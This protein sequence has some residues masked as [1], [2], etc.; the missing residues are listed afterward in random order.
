MQKI[1]EK[2][3]IPHALLFSGPDKVGKKKIA[4]SFAQMIFNDKSD[5]N[6][7]PDFF[8]LA[9]LGKEIKIEEIR[10]LQ[11]KLS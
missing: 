11:E 6:G 3:N 8:L 9:S 2:G 10:Q 7:N 1:I 4:M 5:L